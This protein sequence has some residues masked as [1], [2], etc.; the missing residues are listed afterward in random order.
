[1]HLALIKEVNDVC[2]WS[3]DEEE[4]SSEEAA[5]VA[6]VNPKDRKVSFEL[7]PQIFTHEIEHLVPGKTKLLLK[8][9]KA[10]VGTRVPERKSAKD[11]ERG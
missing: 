2:P 8:K 1:M 9:S 5:E 3:E 7:K 11:S 10:K 6:D 4:N